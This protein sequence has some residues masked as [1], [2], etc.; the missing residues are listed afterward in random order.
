MN[1]TRSKNF[2]SKKNKIQKVAQSKK[3]RFNTLEFRVK[4]EKMFNSE[5]FKTLEAVVS[6][7][8]K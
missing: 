3:N 2:I 6:L 1:K 5:P 4:K 8:L 7:P